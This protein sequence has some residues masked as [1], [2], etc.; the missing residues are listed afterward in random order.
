[1]GPSGQAENRGNFETGSGFQLNY[2][3][4]STG[5]GDCL[6]LLEAVHISK[7]YGENTILSNISMQINEHDRIGLVGVNGAGKST[8][9]KIL[10]GELLPD[11]GHVHTAKHVRIGY[12]AQDSG[13]NSAR[14][15]A[16][17]MRQVYAHLFQMEEELRG[18]ERQMSDPALAA[19][20]RRY[21]QILEKYAA[22]SERFREMGGYEAEANIR[23]VL[24]GM[25]F[26]GF[27][28]DT[29]IHSLSG[30]QK[31]RLALAKLLLADPDILMLD[32]P[33]NYLD[34]PTLTWLEQYLK[35]FRGALVVVS[36][37]RYFLDTLVHTIYEIERHTVKKYTGNY[38]DYVETK[39]KQAEIELKHYEQQQAEIARMED[40]IRR[41][42]ARASTTKRAQSRRKALERLERLEKP[43]M[44]AKKARFSFGVNRISGKNVLEVR[45]LGFA[46]A[47][48]GPLFRHVSFAL[49]R[50]ESV[51][52][53]GPNGIGKSTLCKI[54]A[55][56]LKPSEGTVQWGANV[57]IAYYEQ[58][59]DDLTPGNTVLEELWSAFP[60]LE[61]R[62]IRTVLGNF[63]FSGED[64]LKP[65][66]A[67]S[68]G[69]KARVAL[70]KLML[71]G[72][73]FFILDE[74]TNHLDLYS[75]E[76][77]ESALAEYEGTILFISHDRYFL[78]KMAERVVELTPDGA[79]HFLG[80]YD[81]VVEKKRE[82]A[83][84]QLAKQQQDVAKMAQTDK[85]FYQDKSS[86]QSEKRTKQEERSR[87]R[88]IERL[89]Q[90]I[91]ALEE[92]IA[93]LESELARPEVYSD[94]TRAQKL[95]DTI[96]ELKKQLD[97]HYE[98]WEK[99]SS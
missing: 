40:F 4:D 53:I 7:S 95:N 9:L 52:L 65:I 12:L 66:H 14:T 79:N 83:E 57:E 82:L 87:K 24:H 11:Q 26:A 55:G 80:N 49:K 6:M 38:S 19:S 50:G 43:E 54:L 99:L 81:N 1:M 3:V 42:L 2:S 97:E 23:S 51:A 36:H 67:L 96:Q 85:S 98:E 46:F 72:A 92:Q 35:T 63:L 74:P 60:Q 86:Y 8:L 10:A 15:I 75:R 48:G 29:P 78:N 22:L 94:Y 30:G 13:L 47:G 62:R 88:K 71:S 68:G 73:N 34:I 58:E 76:M 56:R 16:E 59:H 39:R 32:E 18:L 93:S 27:S 41:N 31:T 5:K 33:T 44:E 25:G 64:V 84:E 20:P 28:P 90:L 61:E 77:L 69:E 17:E 91:F 89:E 21:E 70:A 37:D 45:D